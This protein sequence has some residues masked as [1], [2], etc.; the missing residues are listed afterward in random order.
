MSDYLAGLVSRSQKPHYIL[1]TLC[2]NKRSEGIL[3]LLDIEAELNQ[4]GIETMGSINSNGWKAARNPFKSDKHPSCGVYL[5]SGRYRGYLVAF[6]MDGG[7]KAAWSFFDLAMELGPPQVRGDFKQ[8]LRYYAEKTGVKF[9]SYNPPKQANVDRY[10]TNL[11]ENAPKKR[12]DY[13]H[14]ERGLTD[15]TLDKH[16]VG[17]DVK[18]ERY[19]FPVRDIDGNLVN[20]RYHNSELKPKTLN[21]TGYGEARLWGLDRLASVPKGNTIVITEGEFDAMLVEQETGITAI[22]PTNGTLAWMPEWVNELHQFNVV[23]LWDCD[24]EGMQ[25]LQGLIRPAFK[26][27]VTGGQIPSIKFVQL[28]TPD[29]VDK[30]HKD[31]TD[32]FIKAGGSGEKLLEMI[33]GAEPHQYI[34]PPAHLPE[35]KI[36]ESFSEID[37]EENLG[38]RVSV[39]LYVFGENSEAYA[40]ATGAKVLH[41]ELLDKGKCQGKAEVDEN[42]PWTCN[43]RI[44]VT[45]ESGLMLACIRASDLQIKGYLRDYICHQG[46]RIVLDIRKEKTVREVYAHQVIESFDLSEST[47]L[48]DKPIYVMGGRQV[49]IGPYKATGMVQA[50]PRSQQPTLLVDN[51]EPL[52]ED[53]QSFDVDKARSLLRE[54]QEVD[55]MDLLEDFRQCDPDL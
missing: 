49:H 20:I 13:L 44:P 18:R 3:A 41:C 1:F 52:Q 19:A 45:Y 46:R 42:W 4:L 15:E 51:L 47:E 30:Q 34:A 2:L 14:N 53:W 54:L 32:W 21:Q 16:E 39:K 38:K 28:F 9:K 23:F 55:W 36:L 5:G 10:K 6:N 35:P 48:I 31:A 33:V 43:E 29:Q 11:R 37:M 7:Y 12:L 27:A 26:K 25:A 17:W 40:V 24:K 50:L 22:S 8:V